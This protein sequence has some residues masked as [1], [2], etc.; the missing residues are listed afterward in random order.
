MDRIADMI[1]LPEKP[2]VWPAGATLE[3]GPLPPLLRCPDG[4]HVAV[5]ILVAAMVGMC[6]QTKASI[7]LLLDQN[8]TVWWRGKFDTKDEAV[9]F[10]DEAAAAINAHRANKPPK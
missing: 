10:A 7:V 4:S 8:H 6:W 2:A 5:D 3:K 9:R 1:R